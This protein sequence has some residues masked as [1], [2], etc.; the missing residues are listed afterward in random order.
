M[1]NTR[2]KQWS[3]FITYR[4]L[5]KDC[6]GRGHVIPRDI[7]TGSFNYVEQ[8]DY[9]TILVRQLRGEKEH[10]KGMAALQ[11]FW[12]PKKGTRVFNFRSNEPSAEKKK[13]KKTTNKHSSVIFVLAKYTKFHIFAHRNLKLLQ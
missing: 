10:G 5:P 7:V 3:Y 4:P 9:L 8:N 2:R 6:G 12:S 13:K 1:I 11:S